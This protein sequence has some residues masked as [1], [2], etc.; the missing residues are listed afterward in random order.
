MLLQFSSVSLGSGISNRSSI[1][2]SR[3][4]E[5]SYTVIAAAWL[6]S[7]LPCSQCWI[8]RRLM[9]V[10]SERLRC[11]KPLEARTRFKVVSFFSILF[12]LCVLFVLNS[13]WTAGRISV[14]TTTN[15][16]TNAISY[17]K[18]YPLDKI[19]KMVYN[20]GAEIRV[21]APP[22]RYQSSNFKIAAVARPAR[23]AERMSSVKIF[24]LSASADGLRRRRFSFLPIGLSSFFYS[25][26]YPPQLHILYHK[27]GTLSRGF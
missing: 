9:P 1:S 11:V 12:Y 10:A 23:I 24:N 26:R 15:T 18:N 14:N 7:L 4:C 21:S 8:V 19:Q 5:T 6:K 13:L 22:P 2:T 17:I 25:L 27:S 20:R 16:A 3:T